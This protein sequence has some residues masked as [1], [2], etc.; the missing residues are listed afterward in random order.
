MMD[1]NYKK[2]EAIEF[3]K[4]GE[5]ITAQYY[6]QDGYTI[7]ERNWRIGK[8]EIDLIAQNEDVIVI[9]EVKARSG[10]DEDPLA[11][12]TSDKRRRMIRAADSYIKRLKGQYQYRFDIATITGNMEN[13]QLEIF[14]DAFVAADIF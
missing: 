5:E 11:T 2:K 9:I 4:F 1:K 7:L 6:I 3:G 10:D 13:Y 12:I 14:E 8:T